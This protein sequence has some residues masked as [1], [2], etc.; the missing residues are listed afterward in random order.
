MGEVA[1]PPRRRT[2]P[3]PLVDRV[4]FNVC[5]PA[6]LAEQVREASEAEDRSYSSFVRT[7]L[8]EY[9]ARLERTAA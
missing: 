1:E 4:Q 9:L 6:A 8:R 2:G 5:L 7:A 3:R